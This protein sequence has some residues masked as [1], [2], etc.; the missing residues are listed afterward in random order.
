MRVLEKDFELRRAVEARELAEQ[1]LE[2]LRGQAEEVRIKLD[3]VTGER[4]ARKRA[5]DEARALLTKE[6]GDE[7]LK[8]RSRETELNKEIVA[9]GNRRTDALGQLRERG[10]AWQRWLQLGRQIPGG[11]LADVL[12]PRADL[13]TALLTGTLESG[14][15][16]LPMLAQHFNNVRVEA[17]TVQSGLSGKV[18]SLTREVN[19]LREDIGKLDANRT[20]GDFPLRDYLE[21]KLPRS[22]GAF[23]P[24]Q[25]CRLTEVK[26]EEERWRPA[27]ELFLRNNRFALILDP[28]RHRLAQQILDKEFDRESRR[29]PLVD[30]DEAAKLEARVLPNSLAAKVSTSNSVARAFLDHLLGGV[31]C[32]D[33]PEDF[34]GKA[35]AITENAVLWSRP[36]TT[37]LGRVT[38]FEPVIGSKGLEAIKQRKLKFL[39]DKAEDL[40]KAKDASEK[41]T[42][43]LEGGEE[44]QLGAATLTSAAENAAHLEA[45]KS[46]LAGV[47]TQ[48]KILA[49]PELDA[50]VLEVQRLDGEHTALVAE[51]ALLKNRN[52]AKGIN[53]QEQKRAAAQATENTKRLDFETTMTQVGE[54][55]VIEIREAKAAPLL[56]EYRGWEER[57]RRTV[58]LRGEAETKV[59]TARGEK[60]RER[61]LLRQQFSEFVRFSETDDRN[62]EYDREMHLLE[63]QKVAE[64]QRKS[65]ES[66][67]EW[68]ARLKQHVVGELK[69]R[70][71]QIVIDM[72]QL[73]A[74]INEPIGKNLYHLS[75][76]Q[77]RDVDFDLLWKLLKTG[78]ETTDPLSDA[79]RDP[80]IEEA[81]AK[82]MEALKAAVDS[83]LRQRLDYRE[84]F[85]F[86]MESKDTSLPENT[87]WSSYTRHSGKMSGGENQSPFF[88]A[89]LAAFLRSYHRAEPGSLSRRDTMG[90]VAMDEAFS[91]LSGDGVESC[92]N[93]ANTLGLQLVLAMPDKDAPSA[94]RGA[95]TILMVT[96]SKSIGPDGRVLV[97]NW[98]YPARA[99]ETLA[100]LES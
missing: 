94:L 98:A 81:K 47:K 26:P 33:S 62:D 59:A 90:L 80:E 11:L 37:K 2:G 3:R 97:E 15:E 95:N 25:L 50:R 70:T 86:D 27:L 96:I 49:K 43:W 64:Y 91:K 68:E 29:E 40:R 19:G 87:G 79:I 93:T 88:L 84:Y 36:V 54:G 53:E 39:A 63:D 74:S 32:V 65:D 85:K 5:L 92:M 38:D 99:S 14:V 100:E 48:L 69:R 22:P 24:E 60:I 76:Q 6:G 17:A 21:K 45:K 34:K 89:M 51:E 16:A 20:H 12:Q 52:V 57:I 23:G 72:R 42:R 71:D 55:F 35:R 9:I 41:I 58:D 82:L 44:Q 67:K 30:P 13:L 73:N 1:I 77:R 7:L 10:T 46:E 4:E 56:K 18:G 28:Q 8:L 78:L 31:V 75:W 66:R 83:P 61:S